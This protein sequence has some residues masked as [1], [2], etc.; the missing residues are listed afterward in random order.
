MIKF[1][2]YDNLEVLAKKYEESAQVRPNVLYQ[3]YDYGVSSKDGPGTGFFANMNKFKSIRDFINSDRKKKRKQRK[4]KLAFLI[5]A[6]DLSD[7]PKD[8]MHDGY[9]ENEEICQD[10]TIA[11]IP[12]ISRI[13]PY[14]NNNYDFSLAA[15]VGYMFDNDVNKNSYEGLYSLMGSYIEKTNEFVKS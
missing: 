4:E 3:N 10:G 8:V 11:G 9:D 13:D 15:P 7:I 12:F 14:N 5:T 2:V 1:N 6:K